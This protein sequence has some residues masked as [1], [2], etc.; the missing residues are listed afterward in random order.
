[1]R[2]SMAGIRSED[3]VQTT[4]R[5]A[6]I[7]A[8][9]AACDGALDPSKDEIPT[10]GPAFAEITLN[11]AAWVPGIRSDFRNG[12]YLSF[13]FDRP[14]PGTLQSEGIGF[15]LPGFTGT[16]SSILTTDA[17]P[18][19]L[20]ITGYDPTDSTVEGAFRFVVHSN[21]SSIPT[22]SFEGSFR[23]RPSEQLSAGGQRT[24]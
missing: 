15:F 6:C 17:D 14:M 7:L 8:V 19:L 1:M 4:A 23:I 20:R 13:G 2:S 9:L 5:W 24:P 22:R 3:L 12:D 11:G 21:F 10:E 16:G 18:G